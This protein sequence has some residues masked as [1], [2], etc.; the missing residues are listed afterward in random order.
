MNRANVLRASVVVPTRNRVALLEKCLGALGQQTLRRDEMEV[1]VVDDGST[2]GTAQQAEAV[3]QAV[4]F[5]VRVLRGRGIGPAAARNLG[6]QAA[7]APIVL[8]TD[9]DCEPSATW[10]ADLVVFLEENPSCAGVG[11]TTRRL[12]DSTAA[13]FTDETH[14]MNH[15]GDALDV[16][17]LVTA[18]A[19][20]RRDVLAAAG[21]FDESFP[22]AGGEDPELSFRL[23]SLHAQ[24]A[25]TTGAVV[26]H[27]HPTSAAGVYRMHHRY[28]RGEYILVAKG[29]FNNSTCDDLSMFFARIRESIAIYR[30]RRDLGLA[31]RVRFAVLN[32][33]RYAGVL[34]GYRF[35]ERR[36]RLP[37]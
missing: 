15:P 36:R 20:Y 11:G 12:H 30:R 13:R 2:D 16:D 17:Y 35:E 37:A 10:A 24:L 9:D 3:G 28:G 27:N 8:F 7:L 23:K 26:L 32:I 25:K 22:C 5:E 31:D 18:N 19:A 4:P 29:V 34:S 14:C 21:G 1:I 6:W 33:I